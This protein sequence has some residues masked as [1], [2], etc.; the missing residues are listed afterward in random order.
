MKLKL[1]ATMN[2]PRRQAWDAFTAPGKRMQWNPGLENFELIQGRP[3]HPGA[4]NAMSFRAGRR[5]IEATE[6]IVACEAPE[7]YRSVYDCDPAILRLEHRFEPV[8]EGRLDLRLNADIRF[9]GARMKLLSP[10]LRLRI[11]DILLADLNGFRDYLEAG[12]GTEA[13]AP[14]AADGAGDPPPSCPVP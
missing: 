5:I 11:R 4:L 6:W 13:S 14:V 2:A 3:G 12:G 1:K 10:F 8:G 9:R 7:V